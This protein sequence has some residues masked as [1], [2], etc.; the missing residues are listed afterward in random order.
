MKARYPLSSDF[1]QRTS[2][3]AA[4]LGC[5]LTLI[6][7]VGTI[8]AAYWAGAYWGLPPWLK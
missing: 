2:D 7:F 4:W 3:S 1:E 5:L 6:A 8:T